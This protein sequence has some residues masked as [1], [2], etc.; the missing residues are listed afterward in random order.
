MMM[1][2]HLYQYLLLIV[3]IFFKLIADGRVYREL[4]NQKLFGL[5]DFDNAFSYWN[6][7]D[8]EVVEDNPMRGLAKKIGEDDI[9]AI[10]VPIP[11]NPQIKKNK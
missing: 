1:I 3:L 6:K 11:E 2:Y 10:M 4:R 8:G 5:F 7:L 9:Y